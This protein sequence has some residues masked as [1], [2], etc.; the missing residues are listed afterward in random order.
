MVIS[1]PQWYITLMLGGMPPANKLLRYT[2]TALNN[3]QNLESITGTHQTPEFSNPTNLGPLVQTWGLF[4][5]VPGRL[6]P[7]S[8]YPS[9]LHHLA[10]LYSLCPNI[11]H[12][13]NL[14]HLVVLGSTRKYSAVYTPIVL[15][16]TI[17]ATW[18]Y[19]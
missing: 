14:Y 5:A 19:R 10:I 2:V 18:Q 8:T 7:N 11:T 4:L 6:C 16:L 1:C 17:F 9:N 3:C 13:G 15:A 12:L